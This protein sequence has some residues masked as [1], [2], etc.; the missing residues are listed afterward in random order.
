[1]LPE[2]WLSS[3]ISTSFHIAVMNADR[4]L[5]II[6]ICQL[7]ILENDTALTVV[8]DC[9]RA[10]GHHYHIGVL[11]AMLENLVTF[12]LEVGVSNRCY[13]IN[14]IIIELDA[15]ADTERE[16][17]L[18]PRRIGTN[19]RLVKGPQ[20]GKLFDIFDQLVRIDPINTRHE[21]NVLLTRH[22]RLEAALKSKRPGDAATADNPSP[23]QLQ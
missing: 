14:Q 11:Q 3:L 6:E 21:T 8:A 2:R 13:F 17:G 4:I 20:L 5:N 15:H 12:L 10:V 16:S 7:P 18:H 19:R 9:S 23:I 22:A 1:M